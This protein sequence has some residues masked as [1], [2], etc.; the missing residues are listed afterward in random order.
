MNL[1]SRS[2]G[3][4]SVSNSLW[5]HDLT[6]RRWPGMGRC[7][8]ILIRHPRRSQSEECQNVHNC[9]F[10]RRL[11]LRD[12]PG[13]SEKGRRKHARK[14]VAF[15]CIS[16]LLAMIV[17]VT[18]R[19]QQVS[20]VPEAASSTAVQLPLSGRILETGSVGTTQSVVN[21][22]GTSSVNFIN[23]TVNVQG[24][25]FGSM[26]TGQ[27]T[28][29]IL[30]L[31]L[32]DAIRRGLEYNLGTFGF[33]QSIRQARGERYLVRSNLLPNLNANLRQVVE[34]VDLRALGFQGNIPGIPSIV[35]PFNFFDLRATLTQTVADLTA[36][37][38]YRAAGKIEKAAILLAKDA[39]DQVVLAVG[40]S[41]LEVIAA[42][43]R[44]EAAQARVRTA[45]SV[46]DQAVS[47]REAGVNARIDVTRTLVELQTEQQRLRGLEN[48]VAKLKLN[49]ARII[50]LPIEQEFALTDS[51]PYTPLQ[52]VTEEQA[53]QRAYQNRAD[54]QSA[55]AQVRA[56]EMAHKAASAERLPSLLISADYG[57]IGLNPSNSHGTFTFVG[58]MRI[59]IFQ[60]GRVRGDVLEADA[61]LEQRKAEL[62]DIRGRI[63]Y[64]VRN[65]FLDL[66]TA[67]DQLGAAQSNVSLAHETLQFARDRF[68]A[69]VTDTVEVVQAEESVASAD[70]DLIS[71]TYSY[72]LAKVSLARAVGQAEQGISQFLPGR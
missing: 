58:T 49:I 18:A 29:L 3:L 30:R 46:Y 13:R 70:N 5:W 65:A 39:G 8:R 42:S 14:R 32:E 24:P 22:G 33:T 2:K 56:A 52:G 12:V 25:Y 37:R 67:F 10:A 62:E 60:G 34:Q 23:S 48:D 72:N 4:A 17:V 64:D 9:S 61:A 71:A 20:G 35:G 59:P 41:Y 68:S 7:I 36:L 11:C 40:G 31:S 69:G 53:L 28:R 43:A 6:C 27:A 15:I 47:R 66:Q 16:L 45:Q 50:G 63:D 55:E 21:P 1:I 26:P 19:A 38:N 44:V 54:F 57:A 51:L